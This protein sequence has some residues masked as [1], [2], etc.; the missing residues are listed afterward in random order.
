MC[1]CC[2]GCDLIIAQK[3]ALDAQVRHALQK[4]GRD[5]SHLDYVVVGTLDQDAWQKGMG[6]G[7]QGV[8]SM[9]DHV[10]DFKEV[11]TLQLE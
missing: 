10:A 9:L 11:L 2:S 8:Q 1:S 5:T 6:G 7:E 3:D 4:A